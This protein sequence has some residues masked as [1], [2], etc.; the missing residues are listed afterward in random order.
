MRATLCCGIPL[1]V[2]LS[3]LEDVRYILIQTCNVVTFFTY[4][5]SDQFKTRA[6]VTKVNALVALVGFA[7]YLGKA[8]ESV[9][10]AN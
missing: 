1:Y 3:D 6:I 4:Y 8:L 5:L 7:T 10:I 2:F 9:L